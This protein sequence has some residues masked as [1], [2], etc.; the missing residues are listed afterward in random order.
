MIRFQRSTGRP[1]ALHAT[2]LILAASLA[3]TACGGGGS[4][5]NASQ[6]AQP[7]SQADIDKALQ[8]P[9]ELTFWTWVPNIQ[10]E[11]DLFQKKYPAIKVKVVNAGQGEPQ[12][13]KLRTALKAGSGAPDA[14]QIE[15]QYVPTFSITDSLLDLRPYGASAL[16]DKFVDWTWKQVSGS[17]GQVWAVPQDTGPMGMLYRKDI[18]DK[19]GITPPKT[20]D[21][22]AT[23]AKKLHA[24][25]PK[26]AM[27]NLASNQNGVWMG[28]LWQAGAKPFTTTGKDSVTVNVNDETSK[29]LGTYWNGLIK[30]GSVS[31]DPDFT[32]Q[33]YQALNRGQY[34]TWLTAAWGPVFL[35][36]SAKSTSGKWRAAPLPQWDA[37]KPASGNWGGSTTAVIKGTKNA[38]AAAELAKFLNT[39]TESTKM[40]ATQQFLF[41]ATKGVLTDPSFVAEK[42]TFYGGQTVNQVFSDIS[43]TVNTEFQWPPFLD[44]TVNDWDETVGKSFA[45]KSDP[46]AALDQWQ[47]RTTTYAQNQGFKVNK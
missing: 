2:A 45:D 28:L 5:S 13:T 41:P 35:S 30:E 31:T 19:Y 23:A 36:G 6:S 29:K 22:F 15:F 42:P 24:A 47:S 10:K 40:F 27:T 18:F 32:D 11:V 3:L 1:R 33:W 43:S 14:V 21:E 17:D 8:T 34:A 25:D 16:K 44:Q 37:S 9:T 46:G 12:Y 38:I 7:V 26:V 4:G 39:D 20:W